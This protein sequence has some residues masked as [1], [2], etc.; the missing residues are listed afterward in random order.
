MKTKAQFTKEFKSE[1]PTLKVGSD[2]T[3]YTELEAADYEATIEAWVEHAIAE[4]DKAAA[5]EKAQAD[6]LTLLSK[7]GIT[8]DEAALLLS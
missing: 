6:K 8:S 5:L 3:G 7:L 2:E 1:F 4:Q